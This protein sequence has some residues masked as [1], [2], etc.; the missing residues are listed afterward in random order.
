MDCT[1]S[2]TDSVDWVGGC[3]RRLAL[4]ENLFPVPRGITYNSYLILDE[5]TAL[6]DTVD[7]AISRQFLENVFHVLNGRTLDYLVIDHME[8]DHC[9]NIEELLLRFPQLKL[10]GNAKTWALAQQ[11]YGMDLAGRTL[12][13]AENDTLSLGRHRLRFFLTP[14]VHWPEVMMAYE[15]EEK[16][17][18][19][20]DAF[21]AFGA[22]NGALFNDEI[23][24]ERD[25]LPEARRYYGNIV[26]KYGLQVQAALKKL[27]RL[28]LRMIC[29]L[30]GPVWRS[31]LEGLFGKYRLWSGYEPEERA[32]A[33]FYGSMYGNTENAAARLA[34]G[35]AEHGFSRPAM[36]DVSSTHASTLIA[37]VFRCS[38]LVL[39]APTYNNGVY[40]AMLNFLH[41]MRAL[42]LQNRTVALIE[43]GSWAPASAKQMRALLAEMKQMHI[44][45]PVVT[46][47]SALKED[48][49][50]QLLELQNALLASLAQP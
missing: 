23:A 25:W 35:L 50:A 7:S 32:I 6:M 2:L 27:S 31:D 36:Y 19:S 47:R 28:D 8:P 39:A 16:L 42:N 38:H 10:V 4:F 46:I 18:F 20:A 40:P 37:E 5:K 45:E 1:R 29:P 17:L 12:T 13:V 44:L 22:L 9:A 48:S 14:M 3:D 41:D 21:G 34:C 24:F 49:A 33:L 15:E 30:H 43:N 26:G 11:F